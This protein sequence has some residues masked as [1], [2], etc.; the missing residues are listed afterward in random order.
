M[1]CILCARGGPLREHKKAHENCQKTYAVSLLAHHKQ[2][3]TKGVLTIQS[4]FR[5]LQRQANHISP[6]ENPRNI[7]T[8]HIY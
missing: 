4:L 8:Y 5:S 3:S 1:H 2:E 7:E 6:G